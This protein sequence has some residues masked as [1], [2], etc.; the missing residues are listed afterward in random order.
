MHPERSPHA[1]GA[2]DLSLCIGDEAVLEPMLVGKL[3]M[4]F[5]R[6]RAH[7]DQPN[8]RLVITFERIAEG[9]RLFCAS[10]SPIFRVKEN[11][12]GLIEREADRLTTMILGCEAR[13]PLPGLE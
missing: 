11:D 10:G 6:V 3:P 9:A 7:A 5:E 13:R 2:R 4:T 8:P 1:E 12:A